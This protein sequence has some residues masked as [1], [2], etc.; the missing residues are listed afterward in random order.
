MSIKCQNL[1]IVVWSLWNDVHRSCLCWSMIQIVERLHSLYC[2]SWRPHEW[3]KHVDTMLWNEVQKTEVHFYNSKY[4][5]CELIN[6]QKKEH[7]KP[8]KVYMK[9]H[10]EHNKPHKTSL[11]CHFLTLRFISHPYLRNLPKIR[12]SYSLSF[13]LFGSHSTLL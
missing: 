6:V 9:R 8:H 11:H 12:F 13:N 10:T 5:L 4:G 2:E 3:P 1:K 7:V